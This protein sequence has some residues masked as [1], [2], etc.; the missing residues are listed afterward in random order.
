MIRISRFCAYGNRLA[1]ER[2][3]LG[4]TPRPDEE[5]HKVSKH[6]Y[7]LW[8][9]AS[10]NLHIDCDSLAQQTLSFG[11]A[12]FVGK[13]DS[14]ASVNKQNGKIIENGRQSWVMATVNL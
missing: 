3:R 6:R 10:D 7:C 5:Y 9:L 2:F 1:N 11:V 8:M 14:A 12:A 13:Q 4:I